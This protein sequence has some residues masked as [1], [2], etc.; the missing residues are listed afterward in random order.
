MLW[1]LVRERKIVFRCQRYRTHK[2]NSALLRRTE[3]TNIYIY[4]YIY[5]FVLLFILPAIFFLLSLFH[6]PLWW[7]RGSIYLLLSRYFQP[8]F[9]CIESMISRTN[10]CYNSAHEKNKTVE[11]IMTQTHVFEGIQESDTF[12]K[13]YTEVNSVRNCVTLI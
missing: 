13:Y 7:Q 10:K 12:W 8:W 5:V 1:S 3:Q 4:I 11:K 6:C 2:V 9:L